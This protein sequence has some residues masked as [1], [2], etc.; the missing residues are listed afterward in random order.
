MKIREIRKMADAE[1]KAAPAGCGAAADKLDK[2]P[3]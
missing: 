3:C 2:P 1:A